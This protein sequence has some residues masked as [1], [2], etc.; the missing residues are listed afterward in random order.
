MFTQYDD[1][2]DEDEQEE[3]SPQQLFN[4]KSAPRSVLQVKREPL[5]YGSPSHH[6]RSSQEAPP[7]P[8]RGVTAANPSANKPT[9]L[10]RLKPSDS[11]FGLHSPDNLQI[12]PLGLNPSDIEALE[13]HKV[14]V[15]SNVHP[16]SAFI[17]A[18]KNDCIHCQFKIYFLF[19][20]FFVLTRKENL[21]VWNNQDRVSFLGCLHKIDNR[22]HWKV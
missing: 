7:P 10:G 14:Q 17:M 8:P 5:N 9:A 15:L 16:S 1:D 2:E 4:N 18:S 12:L 21:K 22:V 11:S 6:A 20:L 3:E 19:W 13:E